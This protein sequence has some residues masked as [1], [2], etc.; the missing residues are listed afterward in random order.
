MSGNSFLMDFIQ[1]REALNKPAPVSSPAEKTKKSKIPGLTN[2]PQVDTGI[3]LAG[4]IENKPGKKEVEKYFK[5]RCEQL[6][7][8]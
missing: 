1:R 6:E 7:N 5:A 3:S 4:I 2:L 8:S